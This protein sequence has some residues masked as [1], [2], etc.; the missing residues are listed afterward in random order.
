V[1]EVLSTWTPATCSIVVTDFIVLG[2]TIT[3]P[4]PL[5]PSA[6][7]HHH[8]DVGTRF[9]DANTNSPVIFGANLRRR[10]L[11]FVAMHRPSQLVALASIDVLGASARSVLQTHHLFL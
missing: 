4:S 9:T 1:E 11:S 6:C 2:A 10:P 5:S 8:T 3:R 7:E